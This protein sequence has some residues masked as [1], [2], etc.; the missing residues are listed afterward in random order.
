MDLKNLLNE[1][2]S[3]QQDQEEESRVVQETQIKNEEA[4]PTNTSPSQ[5]PKPAVPSVMLNS[6]E[7]YLKQQ[8][9]G[10][11]NSVN[12]SNLSNMSNLAF[13]QPFQQQQPFRHF[14][15]FHQPV[16]T[17]SRSSIRTEWN[18]G[19]NI[20]AN[21]GT[22]SKQQF[23]QYSANP[24]YKS[25]EKGS[26][27]GH[28][29]GNETPSTSDSSSR[30]ASRQTSQPASPPPPYETLIALR[31]IDR[32]KSGEIRNE[33]A[34]KEVTD[35]FE[36]PDN[37]IL[38]TADAYESQQ[39]WSSTWKPEQLEKLHPELFIRDQKLNKDFK[40]TMRDFKR[41]ADSNPSEEEIWYAKDI[42]L[43]H[44]LSCLN[45]KKNRNCMGCSTYWKCVQGIAEE[46]KP[47]G[48]NDLLHFEPEHS[49]TF[50]GYVGMNG[51]YEPQQIEMLACDTVNTLFY[52]DDPNAVAI[53]G[54]IS[55]NELHK[56][57]EEDGLGVTTFEQKNF[58]DP[59]Y[60]EKKVKV[61]YG[62]Q[63]L[64][65]T[66]VIPSGWV[67]WVIRAGRGLSFSASWNM[68]RLAH[69][70]D[71]RRAVEFNRTLSMFKPINISSLVISAAYQKLDE[72][73]CVESLQEKGEVCNFLVKALPIVKTLVL[74]EILGEPVHLTATVVLGY[75]L[76]VEKFATESRRSSDL[77]AILANELS[78]VIDLPFA[79]L[80]T[81]ITEED[82]DVQFSCN[83]CKY[84][85]FNTRRSCHTCKGYDLCEPCYAKFGKRHNH[86]MK[87]HRKSTVQSLLDLVENIRQALHDHEVEEQKEAAKPQSRKRERKELNRGGGGEDNNNDPQENYD[88]EIIE[89]ICGNNKD[90]GFMISCEKCYAWLHGKC[91]GISKRNEPE[92]YY[93]PRCV[94]KPTVIN[95]KLSPKDF[96]P[97]EKLK[98]YNLV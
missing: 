61:V 72:L 71:A 66:V 58:I 28:P 46:F 83:T 92:V 45:S 73:E 42:P 95:A 30:Q 70:C 96:S 43:M 22:T 29:Q 16:E 21:G 32:F 56:L 85:L 76:I 55:P 98:E 9:P 81:D 44:Q 4:A 31:T 68:L 19:P 64:G 74:E 69:I 37:P 77:P 78:Q 8:L 62:V 13:I 38:L 86:K 40:R 41:H 26:R 75:D 35:G 51:S 15:P 18:R 67:H 39:G 87:R 7:F 89:C 1:N 53:W 10:G 91:V 50:L 3:R 14:V 49:E 90:L 11:G 84:I 79:A 60:L 57:S 34:I 36:F 12:S 82:E 2:I 52:A 24:P 97:E 59:T 27:N 65:Q 80:D 93:C 94:K 47:W 23:E 88:E 20:T 17:G 63:K 54:L 48:N 33:L 5:T 25:T 6:N